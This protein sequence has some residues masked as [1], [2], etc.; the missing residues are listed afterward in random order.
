[1]GFESSQVGSSRLSGQLV[2][3][4]FGF[5]IVSGQVRLVIG[6]FSVGLFQI[7]NHIEQDWIR[8]NQISPSVSDLVRSNDS[9]QLEFLSD[10]Y[11]SHVSFTLIS[12]EL[13]SFVF[14]SSILN[15]SLSIQYKFYLKDMLNY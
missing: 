6:S 10:A 2:S 9:N 1:L 8:S 14:I 5:R 12:I 11:L 13:N 4:H 3:G 7:L 15:S